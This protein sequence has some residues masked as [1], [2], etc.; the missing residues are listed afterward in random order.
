M[1]SAGSLRPHSRH[2][3]MGQSEPLFLALAFLEGDHV[4]TG[5]R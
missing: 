1:L 3:K 4:T 2:N 5:P